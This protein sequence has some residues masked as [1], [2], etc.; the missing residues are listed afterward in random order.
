M[1]GAA[2]RSWEQL[3]APV[4]VS[5]FTVRQDT[6]L[7]TVP[8]RSTMLAP[9]STLTLIFSEPVA[10][11]LGSARPT[12][13]PA[14]VGRWHL[15]DAHTL[16]FRPKGFGFAFGERVRVTLPTA[17]HLAGQAGLAATRTLTWQVSQGSVLRAQQ[18][19]AELGYL[20]LR[21]RARG[22]TPHTLADQLAAA[23]SPPAGTF[24]W[25]YPA[26]RGRLGPLWRAS[27]YGV[28]LRGSVMAF[29]ADHGLVSDGVLGSKL[30]HV[31]VKAALL[32]EVDRHPYNYVSVSTAS[33]EQLR[34]W[35]NGRVVYSTLCNTGIASRPTALGTYPVYARYVS[36]TMSGTNPDGSH[37]ND[38][39]VPW[40]AYFND[41]DAVHGFLRPGY[42]Y[43]QSLG[44]V[45]LPY[46]AAQAVYPYDL[47]GTLVDIS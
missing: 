4:R 45:E 24:S 11:V 46:S 29:E 18:L 26:L 17:V 43:P 21:W 36:T 39:G 33:P 14:T 8:S 38:P 6:Q 3:S 12:L 16:T 28:V 5:W 47:I 2:A 22:T 7:L 9:T 13:I 27:H 42:G 34:V 25:R 32:G 19:L 44:C 20:P 30:W 31:L 35:R 37:Y 40:V 1:V 10:E 23:V 41:G 15:I